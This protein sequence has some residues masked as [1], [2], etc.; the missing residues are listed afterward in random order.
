MIQ[1]DPK[2]KLFHKQ[3]SRFNPYRFVI[4]LALLIGA[5]YVLLGYQRG[6]IKE[7]FLPTGTPTRV[8]NS[9]ALEGDAQFTAG[10]LP[11][12]IAA[13]QQ[14]VELDPANARLLAELAR[15]EVYYSSLSTKLA[16]R[17]ARLEEAKQNIDKAVE[18]APEDSIVQAI[19]ALVYDWNAPEDISG[20]E[21]ANNLTKAEQSAI[22]ALQLDSQNALALA[23]YAE[24]LVDQ[25][26]WLQAEQNIELA[27][28]R[29]DSLM[30]VH[31]VSGY[32]QE[33][34]SNYESAIQEYLKAAE[35]TPNFTPLY[36]Q[37]GTN[38]RT[39]GLRATDDLRQGEMYD[40]ALEYYA[41]AV[42]INKQIGVQDALPYLSISKTYSQMGEFFAAALNVRTALEMLPDDADIYGQLGVVYFKA[43]NYE[44]AIPALQCA[45]YGCDAATSCEVRRCNAE[46]EAPIEITGLPLSSYTLIYFYTYGSVLAGMYRE[47]NNYCEEAVKVLAEV[48]KSYG[49]DGTINAIISPSEQICNSAGYA[50]P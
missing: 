6:E 12:A 5:T 14:G 38:Y 39:L 49:S 11:K 28:A 45:V 44:S 50:S 29:D 40:K 15:I 37:I 17:I 26:K 9:Y 34:L 21:S 4:I 46:T 3:A 36:I 8:A 42:A 25:Q 2:R 27:L 47:G 22:R 20:E 31:R 1:I 32:V 23:Y 24:I 30:D 18:L 16:D 43:R 48:R 33:S 19:R 35:I 10:N 13:Y 7:L 41:K